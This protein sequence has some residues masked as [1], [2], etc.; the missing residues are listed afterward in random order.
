M[1]EAG[2]AYHFLRR[3]PT[4]KAVTERNLC[5]A[6]ELAASYCDPGH[7]A[8]V[9]QCCAEPIP[10]GCLWFARSHQRRRCLLLQGPLAHR[11]LARICAR[12]RCMC[13]VGPV[14]QQRPLEQLPC[15]LKPHGVLLYCRAASASPQWR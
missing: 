4:I 7:A 3:L 1:G 10:L 6:D 14:P 13:S 8:H 9:C 15:E 12:H 2:A 11:S 5:F